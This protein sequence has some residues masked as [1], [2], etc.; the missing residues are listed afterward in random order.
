M[1][2]IIVASFVTVRLSVVKS[3]AQAEAARR[4]TTDASLPTVA[5]R[6]KAGRQTTDDSPEK[7]DDGG[8]TTDN[9]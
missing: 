5:R 7:T 2:P 1:F 9:R 8:L 4:Q 6:A 3:P